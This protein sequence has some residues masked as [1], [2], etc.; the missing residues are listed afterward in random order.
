MKPNKS[1]MIVFAFSPLNT[2]SFYFP[3]VVNDGAAVFVERRR[4][5]FFSSVSIDVSTDKIQQFFLLVQ[6]VTICDVMFGFASDG[7][8][9]VLNDVTVF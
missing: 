9:V 1:K 5:I 8:G 3:F 4:T 7:K 2:W 6:A